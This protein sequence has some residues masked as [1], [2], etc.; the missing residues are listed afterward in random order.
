MTCV[1]LRGLFLRTM[2]NIETLVVVC[3]TRLLGSPEPLIP[4]RV[5][6]GRSGNQ[7]GFVRRKGKM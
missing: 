3:I 4:P 7:Q 6:S 1:S 5:P 2:Y